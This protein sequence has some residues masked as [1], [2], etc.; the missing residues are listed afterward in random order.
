MHEAFKLFAKHC[1]YGTA[2]DCNIIL[3]TACSI[4]TVNTVYAVTCWTWYSFT[5]IFVYLN[6]LINTN[7]KGTLGGIT[8][9]GN[10]SIKTMMVPMAWAL[11]PFVWLAHWGCD[12]MAAIFQ[13]TFSH[14]FTWKK[15]Y[16]F[17]LRFHWSF[18][19]MVQLTILQHW[20]R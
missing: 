20:F 6:T 13:T 9:F 10:I 12:N 7:W 4:W 5:R 11:P 2:A 3:C 18:F 17:W 1:N 15:M 19:P 16:Q 8:P 14:A